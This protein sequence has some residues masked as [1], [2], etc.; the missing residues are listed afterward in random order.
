MS[1][2]LLERTA[3]A[4]DG[5]PP[6]VLLPAPEA[7]PGGPLP[8]DQVTRGFFGANVGVEVAHDEGL[9]LL[10]EGTMLAEIEWT[11]KEFHR[12]DPPI[13]AVSYITHIPGFDRL[14]EALEN[15]ERFVMPY[16]KRVELFRLEI[17]LGVGVVRRMPG[18]GAAADGLRHGGGPEL[19]ARSPEHGSLLP[20]PGPGEAV[21]RGGVVGSVFET[22]GQ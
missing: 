4:M 19:G 7:L 10:N 16:V 11:L 14:D 13:Q 2:D 18:T 5:V 6:V 21:Q 17:G 15:L 20:D 9:K 12:A 3:V 1:P 8:A 22:P